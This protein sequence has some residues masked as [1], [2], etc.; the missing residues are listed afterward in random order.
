MEDLFLI[1]V[2]ISCGVIL[3]GIILAL[4]ISAQ[5]T[6]A[7]TEEAKKRGARVFGRFILSAGLPLPEKSQCDIYSIPGFY[8]IVTPGAVFNI[9]KLKVTSVSIK[10]DEE[11][12]KQAVSSVGGAVLGGAMFGVVGAAIGGRAKTTNVHE[13]KN[14]LVFVYEKDSSVDFAVFSC[15][16]RMSQARDFVTQFEKCSVVKSKE[17]TI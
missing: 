9:D 15:D 4:V 2:I 12:S 13:Y 11:I 7:E 1:T 17:I 16:K 8:Q 14:F 5:K 3:F 6:K 10:T